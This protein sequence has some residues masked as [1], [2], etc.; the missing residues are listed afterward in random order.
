M[1]CIQIIAPRLY[2][3]SQTLTIIKEAQFFSMHIKLYGGFR[4]QGY[5]QIIQFRLGFS[6]VLNPGLGYPHLW[7]PHIITNIIPVISHYPMNKYHS[8]IIHIPFIPLFISH[9]LPSG[10]LTQLWKITMLSMG[11]STMSMAIFN[12]YFDITRGMG[13]V[14]HGSTQKRAWQVQRA[15]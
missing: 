6:I 2:S 8:Y 11:K 10:N 14:P 12:S 15:W 7:K 13:W 9:M 5:P 1:K 3:S 4:E